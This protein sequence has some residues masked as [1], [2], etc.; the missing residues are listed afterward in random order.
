M[1]WSSLCLC[2]LRFYRVLPWLKRGM[3]ER[4]KQRGWGSTELT[5]V[6]RCRKAFLHTTTEHRR[7]NLSSISCL[8]SLA[9]WMN[10]C[11]VSAVFVVCD[12]SGF[13]FSW[14]LELLHWCTLTVSVSVWCYGSILMCYWLHRKISDKL[15]QLLM[16][17]WVVCFICCMSVSVSVTGPLYVPCVSYERPR[18]LWLQSCIWSRGLCPSHAERFIINPFLT[19]WAAENR[20]VKHQREVSLLLSFSHVKRWGMEWV[21]CVERV[22]VS[23]F[24]MR[25]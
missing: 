7:M 23:V 5:E 16:L 3:W 12:G 15:S 24:N 9:R 8:T 13:D 22:Y 14:R 20:G 1:V 19:V 10:A 18:L 21:V 2:Y 11:A 25:S 6:L 17:H 4:V